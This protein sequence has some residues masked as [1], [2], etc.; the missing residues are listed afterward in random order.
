MSLKKIPK[1]KQWLSNNAPADFE[2]LI[3]ECKDTL[4]QGIKY[5]RI[6]TDKD[7]KWN[8]HTT[9]N[10]YNRHVSLDPD[11]QLKAKHMKEVLE[12]QGRDFIDIILGLAI[13]LGIEQGRRITLTN[14]HIKSTL[15]VMITCS[16]I[17]KKVFQAEEAQD[18]STKKKR[19]DK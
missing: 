12:A 15:G 13:S 2:E 5:E 3:K 16:D 9:T 8:G 11:F 7:I 6:N 10:P 19:L 18:K 17:L 1:G 14:S 4:L